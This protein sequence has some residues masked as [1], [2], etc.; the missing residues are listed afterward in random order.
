MKD[1]ERE[2]KTEESMRLGEGRTYCMRRR[3]RGEGGKGRVEGTRKE[4]R[5]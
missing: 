4:E 2:S 5:E 3:E 1:K